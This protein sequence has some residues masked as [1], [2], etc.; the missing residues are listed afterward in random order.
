VQNYSYKRGT[1]VWLSRSQG[2]KG[3]RCREN[4]RKLRASRNELFALEKVRSDI[5]H[6][7]FGARLDASNSR[8]ITLEKRAEETRDGQGGNG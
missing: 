3:D 7:S 5:E 6:D 8:A 4:R 1:T 2:A